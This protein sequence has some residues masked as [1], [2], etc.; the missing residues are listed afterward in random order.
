VEA[1]LDA[2]ATA[3]RA[4]LAAHDLEGTPALLA[5]H[6]EDPWIFGANE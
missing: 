6:T 1:L 2:Q 4:L 3:L 5:H